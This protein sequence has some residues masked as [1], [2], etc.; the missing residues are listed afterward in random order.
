VDQTVP[1]GPAKAQL[2]A[3]LDAALEAGRIGPETMALRLAAIEALAD[4]APPAQPSAGQVAAR[5]WRRRV[6]VVVAACVLAAAGAFAWR[7]FAGPGERVGAPTEQRA[8]QQYIAAL[9]AE[10]ADRVEQVLSVRSPA[11]AQDLAADAPV[12]IRL[13]DIQVVHDFGPDFASARVVG[14]AAGRPLDASLTLSRDSGA[15]YVVAGDSALSHPAD[16]TP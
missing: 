4:E 6:G 2:E 8:V 1:D 7:S 12:P 9:N 13:S 10:D 3:A 14:T 16:P 5:R 11:S 15:W